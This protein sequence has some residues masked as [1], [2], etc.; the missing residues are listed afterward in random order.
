MRTQPV[1]TTGRHLQCSTP[2]WQQRMILRGA[3]AFDKGCGDFRTCRRRDNG[4]IRLWPTLIARH[5]EWLN[6][7]EFFT[8]SMWFACGPNSSSNFLA[9]Y[10]TKSQLCSAVTSTDTTF[11]PRFSISKVRNRSRDQFPKR[12]DQRK[13]PCPD[14][15][16]LRPANPIAQSLAHDRG[17]PSCDKSRNRPD[18]RPLAG[19][20]KSRHCS[21]L[22][23]L[24]QFR[25]Q[26]QHFPVSF[27]SG[28]L[29]ALRMRLAELRDQKFIDK[30]LHR[31]FKTKVCSGL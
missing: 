30:R 25:S 9:G 11:A 27:A 2:W 15:H 23:S 18:L 17:L 31:F 5:L 6:Q 28:L 14:S 29:R 22:A 8:R 16:P 1:P 3:F 19:R 12:V 24:N 26:E 10:G 20:R 4:F 7:Y 21:Q 13:R